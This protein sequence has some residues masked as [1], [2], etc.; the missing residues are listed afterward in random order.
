[1]KKRYSYYGY[2]AA[3]NIKLTS[4]DFIT[5][6]SVIS[7]AM[8]KIKNLL[9]RTIYDIDGEIFTRIQQEIKELPEDKKSSGFKKLFAGN[10][11]D[12]KG[13]FKYLDNRYQDRMRYMFQ[14]IR[15]R[16]L[17]NREPDSR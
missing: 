12:F 10:L 5:L 3:T 9:G 16:E 4:N 13:R 15:K 7:Q 2:S 11:K 14:E 1:M 8:R 6:R 17:E